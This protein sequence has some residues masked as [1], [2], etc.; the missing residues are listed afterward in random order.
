[1]D[2]PQFTDDR[3]RMFEK[4]R[5][6]KRAAGFDKIMTEKG[7]AVAVAQFILDIGILDQFRAVDP[8]ATGDTDR[9]RPTPK[10]TN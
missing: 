10:P 2:C 5:G 7:V 9:R 3:D 6:V 8:Q 1:M 4:I